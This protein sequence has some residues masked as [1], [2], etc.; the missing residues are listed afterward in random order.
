MLYTVDPPPVVSMNEFRVP[1][2]PAAAIAEEIMSSRIIPVVQ[3][4][5]G[6]PAPAI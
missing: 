5:S 6:V 1:S 2:V 4:P 3:E